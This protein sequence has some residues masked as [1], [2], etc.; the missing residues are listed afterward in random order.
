VAQE[1]VVATVLGVDLVGQV[2]VVAVVVLVEA[3]VHHYAS[4]SFVGAASFDGVAFGRRL[5]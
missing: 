5:C 1:S 4:F 3:A 2:V